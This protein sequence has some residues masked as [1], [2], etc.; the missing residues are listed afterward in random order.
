MERKPQQ[1]TLSIRVSDGLREFLERAK[2]VLAL[3]RDESVSTSDVAKML[4]ESA[5]DDR[6]DFRL[7]VAG[8]QQDP[9]AS[10]V[11][12]R[13]KSEVQHALARAEW[14]FV[15]QYVQLATEEISENVGMPTSQAFIRLL[16]AF[17]AVRSL[18][19]DHGVGLD[20]YYLSN[21][22][23]RDGAALNDRQLDPDLVPQTV[24]AIIDALQQ[25][26]DREKPV[27]AGRCFY[28][29]LRDESIADLIALNRSLEPFVE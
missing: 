6:L 15:G 24:A 11:A 3:G 20:R 8:L 23:V 26:P 25:E 1:Q 21:L 4:L 29:A 22:G 13:R 16:E 14:V 10:L 9:T 17:L 5:K 7:E 19:A 28:V 2:Q 12:I 27:F 18:R